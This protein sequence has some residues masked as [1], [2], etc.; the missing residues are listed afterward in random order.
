MDK[1]K[2]AIIVLGAIFLIIL[3]DKWVFQPQEKEAK[4]LECAKWLQSVIKEGGN[5]GTANDVNT[6]MSLCEKGINK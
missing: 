4:Q 3:A 1:F 6:L 2:W 5:V